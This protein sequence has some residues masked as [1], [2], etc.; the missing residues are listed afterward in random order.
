MK[1]LAFLLFI[2]FFLWFALTHLPG[3]IERPQV[4]VMQV[5]VQ[6]GR[7][8]VCALTRNVAPPEDWLAS[9]DP[10]GRGWILRTDKSKLRSDEDIASKL[11]ILIQSQADF[12]PAD[13]LNRWLEYYR[14][15]QIE[16]RKDY[17]LQTWAI[18][19][20]EGWSKDQYLATDNNFVFLVG[21]PRGPHPH[22]YTCTGLLQTKLDSHLNHFV[23]TEVTFNKTL[24]PRWREIHATSTS[25][26]HSILGK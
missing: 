11:G 17:G 19:D 3:L 23:I 12:T 9:A 6:D 20:K 1:R 26:V 5:C 13:Y 2:S 24:L 18:V 15:E 16:R 10:T 25:L 21:C 22:Q 14:E 8:G 4:S 7:P